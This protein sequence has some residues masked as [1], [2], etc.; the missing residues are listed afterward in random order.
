MTAG[1]CIITP[2]SGPDDP[3]FAALLA[4]CT[5]DGNRIATRFAENWRSGANRFDRPGELLLSAHLG[6]RLAGFCGRNID[7]YAG[8]PSAGRVRHLYVSSANRRH[9]I[10][11]ALVRAVIDG[12]ERYFRHLNTRAPDTAF[13]FYE[14]LGFQPV[15]GEETVTHRLML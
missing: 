6:G 9:G 8:D 2:L 1:G 12:A 3:G 4:D 10:G 7:P 11:S 14:A 13:A 5:A 15:A